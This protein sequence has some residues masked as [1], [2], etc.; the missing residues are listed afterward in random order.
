MAAGI[1]FPSVTASAGGTGFD[2][3]IDVALPRV[4]RLYGVK[5]GLSAAYGSGVLISG[6]GLVVTVS[7]LL[8]DA[9]NL[10]AVTNDGVTYAADVVHMDDEIQLALLRL[11]ALP[12]YDRRG[13]VV[14]AETIEPSHF[15][16]FEPGSSADLRPGDWVLA[17]G[18]PFKVSVGDEPLSIT[19]GVFSTRTR[20]DAKRKTRDFPYRGQVLVIDAITSNPGAPGGPLLSLDGQWVGLIGRVVTSNL[21]HT[22]FNHALPVETVMQF[23]QQALNPSTD[24]Q[25]DSLPEPYHGIKLF[26]LGYQKNL[27]YL[28]RVKPGSPAHVAGLR[29]DDLIVSVDGRSVTDIAAFREIVRTKQPG[30]SLRLA[31]IRGDQIKNLI[32]VL[33]EQP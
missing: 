18:N 11:H 12:S 17:V 33:E 8:L 7:S 30:E 6:D 19:A 28:E 5:A 20:L 32:L 16:F 13:R 29:K 3:A 24:E 1:L 23:V 27:V 22:H 21:T 4:V 26:E 25:A 10:R 9:E 15:A 31:V 14:P 2:R